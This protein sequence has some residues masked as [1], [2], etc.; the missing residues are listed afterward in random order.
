MSAKSRK[1]IG[2]LN[3]FTILSRN[4]GKYQIPG[5]EEFGELAMLIELEKQYLTYD[6]HSHI[7]L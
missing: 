1:N 3:S 2:M 6:L 4:N 5:T 7:F